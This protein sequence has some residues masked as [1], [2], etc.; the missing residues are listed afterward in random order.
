LA[1]DPK[2][3]HFPRYGGKGDKIADYLQLNLPVFSSVSVTQYIL[4]EA[5]HTQKPNI[6]NIWAIFKI[7]E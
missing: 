3:P 7:I 4:V 1:P 5:K 2:F 6:E